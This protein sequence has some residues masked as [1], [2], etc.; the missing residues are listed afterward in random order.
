MRYISGAHARPSHMLGDERPRFVL[1]WHRCARHRPRRHGLAYAASALVIPTHPAWT[2]WDAL[3]DQNRS[4]CACDLGRA[5]GHLRAHLL[6]CR[7][8]SLA[9]CRRNGKEAASAPDEKGKGENSEASSDASRGS[10]MGSG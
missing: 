6:G 8:R 5:D 9:G 1:A 4:A 3:V 10:K 2:H 7:A